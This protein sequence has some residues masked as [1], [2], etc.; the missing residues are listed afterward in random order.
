MPGQLEYSKVTAMA[1]VHGELLCLDVSHC[2]T[3]C[4][5]L[6]LFPSFTEQLLFILFTDRF[7][8]ANPTGNPY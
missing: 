1:L 7:I 2:F 5:P 3:A 4:G 6:L 8:F